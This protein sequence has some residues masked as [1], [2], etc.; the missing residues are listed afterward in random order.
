M[1]FFH[2]ALSL[3]VALI[4]GTNFVFIHY[5]LDE[6][7]PFTFATLRFFLVA[8]PLIFFLPRPATSWLHLISYGFF[9]GCGQFGLLFWAMQTN[10]TPGLASLIIQMQVFFTIL[11]AVLFFGEDI[12]LNQ[13]VA[14]I[15]CFS[16]LAL[17]INYVDAQTTIIGVVVTLVAAMSWACGNLIVK[18]AGHINILAFLVWSSLFSVPPL[19]LAAWYL[20]GQESIVA[21][22]SQ[23]SWKAWSVVLWQSVGN[24]LIGYG[25]WNMLLSRYSAALVTPWALLV[26]VFGMSA[27][28]V[29]LSEPM[30]W[31]K[32]LAMALICGGL[33]LNMVSN[34]K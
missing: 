8:V 10:I 4:W 26:P 13:V 11:L 20:E 14:L 22:V 28:A 15:V 19:A 6:L 31:W 9:I 32:L 27:S 34:R 23:A 17:I 16:G 18:N 12:K 1:S 21:S 30:P 24:P 5:G 3:L 7:Q 2:Q 25:L 29:L 33:A